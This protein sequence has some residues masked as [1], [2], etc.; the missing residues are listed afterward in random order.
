MTIGDQ[1]IQNPLIDQFLFCQLL[2]SCLVFDARNRPSALEVMQILDQ[3]ETQE[4]G[5]PRSQRLM[6]FFDGSL[7]QRDVEVL[8]E[9]DQIFNQLA[10][11]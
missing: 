11:A 1:K 10:V 2:Q 5:Y 3:L 8:R 6:E 4:Y 7:S 9:R